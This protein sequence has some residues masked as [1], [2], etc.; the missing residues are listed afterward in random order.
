M[1]TLDTDM[2]PLVDNDYETDDMPE[3]EDTP[4]Q[5]DPPHTYT[6]ANPRI[7][8]H[9]AIVIQDGLEDIPISALDEIVI[10]LKGIPTSVF[11]WTQKGGTGKKINHAIK[12]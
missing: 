5:V 10:N 4:T 12:A 3:L 11:Y 8:D 1:S 7:I 6:F 9:N 2:P